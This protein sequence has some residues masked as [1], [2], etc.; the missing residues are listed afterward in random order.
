MSF[1]VIASL[2]VGTKNVQKFEMALKVLTDATRQEPGCTK[3]DVHFSSATEGAY[4]IIEEYLTHEDYLSHI[5]SQHIQS[6]S[7]IA[8]H[9]FKKPLVVL[10]GTKA[11]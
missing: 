4:F 2:S 6:F 10:R 3:Y 1:T 9:L 11:W 8:T 7:Q 5:E